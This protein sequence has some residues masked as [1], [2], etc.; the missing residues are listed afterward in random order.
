MTEVRYYCPRCGAIAALE[1]E[2]YLA[3]KCVTPYPLDGWEYADAYD[4]FEDSAERSSADHSSGRRG[5]ETASNETAGPSRN[6][7]EDA[8]GVEIVCGAD[9]TE[10]EGCGELYYLSFV[11]YEDGEEVDPK[12]RSFVPPTVD[13]PAIAESEDEDDGPRF[14]FKP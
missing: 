14:D 9:E 13:G 7:R 12:D 8:D 11:K 3:D 1:R 2:G 4:G 6:P 10:G 5:G